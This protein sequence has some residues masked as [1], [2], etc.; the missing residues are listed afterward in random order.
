MF[1]K[2]QRK[3][4]APPLTREAIEAFREA[5]DTYGFDGQRHVVPHG[6]YLI[7]LGQPDADKRAQ[8]YASFLDD[9]KRCEALGLGL[10]NL[11]PGSTVGACEPRESIALI[12]EGIN[13]VHAE[14]SGVCILLEGMAGQGNHIGSSFEDLAAIIE[15]VADK[16]RVG[17]CLDTCHLFAAGHDL[18]TPSA[19]ADTMSRF[20]AVVGRQYLR[21]WHLNDSKGA[22]GC[23]KDRHESIG[24]GCIGVEAFRSLM[25]DA[26]LNAM[27]MILETPADDDMVY[28][29]EVSLLYSLKE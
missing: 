14:T 18:R 15:R 20:D 11:H 10:Y 24:K 2:N 21:A 19:Y 3:W 9:V 26:T 13:R 27:P 29:H 22:L 1:L 23:R 8:A 4:D 25:A 16:S 17:V 28:A 5:M 6:S 7:N 12:A